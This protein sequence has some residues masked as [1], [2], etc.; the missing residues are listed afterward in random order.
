MGHFSKKPRPWVTSRR[1]RT[2]LD[3]LLRRMSYAE[4]YPYLVPH[5]TDVDFPH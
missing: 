4:S 2:L 3:G 1:S 5:P